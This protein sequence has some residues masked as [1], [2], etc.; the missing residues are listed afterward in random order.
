ME[1]SVLSRRYLSPL[2][3]TIEFTCP[4]TT[5]PTLA[6]PAQYHGTRSLS[7]SPP[8]LS[9][10]LL[11]PKIP[12]PSTSYNSTDSAFP[13][14]SCDPSIPLRSPSL[15]TSLFIRQSHSSCSTSSNSF[16][17][18]PTKGTQSPC[19]KPILR[20]P[21]RECT[22]ASTSASEDGGVS[23]K[24]FDTAIGL[25]LS[26]TDGDRLPR[27]QSCLTFAVKCPSITSTNTNTNPNTTASESGFSPLSPITRNGGRTLSKS[28]ARLPRCLPRW[29]AEGVTV[30]E[31]DDDDEDPNPSPLYE[32]ATD[33]E[34]E[35]Y[36]EDE[37]GG[38]TSD[39]DL[40]ATFT[41]PSV[42]SPW[43]KASRWRKGVVNDG[44]GGESPTSTPRRRTH[45]IKEIH[46][47]HLEHLS[48]SPSDYEETT[49]NVE[50]VNQARKISI[51]TT[52]CAE[53][54]SRHRSPPPT[55]RSLSTAPTCP[56]AARSPSAAE[57]CRRRESTLPVPSPT[58]PSRGWRSD[59]AG[60]FP[61]PS[62]MAVD[63][64]A[65][66]KAS[67]PSPSAPTR[68]ILRRPSTANEQPPSSTS[69]RSPIPRQLQRRRSAP[70]NAQMD[71]QCANGQM[72]LGH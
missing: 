37:E 53:R 10:R 70:A 65:S 67:L 23:G 1:T 49:N 72:F 66:R 44:G 62:S 48:T 64:A 59:D 32:E 31:E 43:A 46:L 55:H 61:P 25:G 41:I 17:I 12:L 47:N 4:F 11:F 45:D 18:T 21:D 2:D 24:M 27:R 8:I 57:L 29:R 40:Q 30:E 15:L 36:E 42:R 35:G 9:N 56:P 69:L 54:C 52:K 51:M 68:S 50:L 34:D 28:P 39:E 58:Q 26:S 7:Q 22:S 6:S 14:D 16:P 3:T 20:R 38:F 60:L 13:S 19:G 71:I 33:S 5:S 63:L